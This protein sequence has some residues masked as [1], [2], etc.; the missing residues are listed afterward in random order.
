MVAI[1]QHLHAS[2]QCNVNVWTLA[3][4]IK[5]L[6]YKF[7][8][9]LAVTCTYSQDFSV[10]IIIGHVAIIPLFHFHNLDIQLSSVCRVF[11]MLLDENKNF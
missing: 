11:Y 9:A 3:A 2:S 8:I 4:S 10:F 7:N 1:S 6:H 5:V